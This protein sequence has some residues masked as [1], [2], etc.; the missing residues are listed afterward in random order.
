MSKVIYAY[1]RNYRFDKETEKRLA[2]I[3]NELLPDNISTMPNHTIC[4]NDRTAYAVMNS[5]SSL[6]K[7]ESS[8]LLGC[9]YENGDIDWHIPQGRFPDGSY[10]IFRN[11]DDYIELVSDAAGSRTIWYYLDDNL[12]IASTSQRAIILFLGDFV[13]DERVIPW[14]LSTGS[15][16]PEFSWDKRLKRLLA[17]SSVLLDKKNWTLFQNNQNDTIFSVKSCSREQHKTRLRDAISR[18]IGALISIDHSKW[19]LALSGGYDS[20]AILCFIKEQIGISRDFKTVTWGLEKSINQEGND[21]KIA[22][23]I[24]NK[25]S[26]QHEYHHTDISPEP[27]ETIV[28]RFILCGEG[29]IARISGYMDGMEIWRK[30]YDEGVV[31]IIRGDQGFGYAR[32]SSE[33]TVRASIRCTLCSDFE[34]LKNIIEDFGLPAQELPTD[35]KRREEESFSSWRDRLYHQYTLPTEFAALSDI[36]LSYVEVINPLLSKSI[37]S[38][39]RNLPDRLRTNKSIYKEIFDSIGPDIP[40]ADKVAIADRQNILRSKEF[41]ELLKNEINSSYANQLFGSNFVRYIL[42]GISEK[43]PKSLKTKKIKKSLGTNKVKRIK[44]SINIENTNH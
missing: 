38:V 7:S 16:G 41:V 5:N 44:E 34:N 37:L 15:L 6:C 1:N 26:V 11:S 21:A 9:L 28:N 17:N 19:T 2:Q 13:F 27:I 22:Q 32:V 35:L 8:L 18:T 3:C 25:L 40:Y 23:D 20:R 30:F 10:A 43:T 31:G 14:M 24:A 12:F 36:K 33:L 29:R 4:V 42:S 39:V